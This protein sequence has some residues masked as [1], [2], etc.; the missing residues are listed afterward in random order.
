M[1]TFS[2]CLDLSGGGKGNLLPYSCLENS[3]DRGICQAIPSMGTKE[4]D[5][6]ERLTHFLPQWCGHSRVLSSQKALT[7][8]LV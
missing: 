7:D 2:L 4:L 1:E 8:F 3:T 5:A 6:T